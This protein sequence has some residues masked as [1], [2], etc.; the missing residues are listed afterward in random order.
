MVSLNPEN[1]SIPE[2]DTNGAGQANSWIL[3]FTDGPFTGI[4][5]WEFI[6]SLVHLYWW[7]IDWFIHF[8]H[9]LPELN[10]KLS[11]WGW[12]MDKLKGRKSI[13]TYCGCNY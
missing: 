1:V 8:P 12:E 5:P 6:L 11:V 10:T 9:S 4:E 13:V 7:N 3:F 2:A